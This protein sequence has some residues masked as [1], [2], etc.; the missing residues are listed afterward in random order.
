MSQHTLDSLSGSQGTHAVVTIMDRRYSNDM[1]VNANINM[2]LSNHYKQ[3][4]LGSLVVC[5]QINYID[6]SNSALSPVSGV[7]STSQTP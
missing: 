7:A 2:T 6:A 4:L 3:C 1:L 5:L